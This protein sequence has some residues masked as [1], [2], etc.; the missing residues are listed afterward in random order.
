[1]KIC[2]R[3]SHLLFTLIYISLHTVLGAKQLKASAEVSAFIGNDVTMPCQLIQQPENTNIT[4]VQWT[5]LQP[6][7]EGVP[8][9]V[10]N[11]QLGLNIPNSPLSQRVKLAGQSLI[12]KA[13]EMEDAGLYTCSISAFPSGKF[14]RIT[15]LVVEG[16][17]V[18]LPKLIAFG[19]FLLING[20]MIATTY[21]IIRRRRRNVVFEHRVYTD[22]V[23]TV[24][25]D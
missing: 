8:L 9:I 13:V 24:M 10:Y 19:V 23:E 2:N 14:E 25:L 5:L 15:K 7:Q 11:S 16:E 1:M 4:Q 22:T 12:I 18:R 6:E 17:M 3:I 20:A 21:F